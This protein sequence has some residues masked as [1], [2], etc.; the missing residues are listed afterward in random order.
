M[1]TPTAPDGRRRPGIAALF[2][3][4]A[5]VATTALAGCSAGASN[6]TSGAAQD[7]APAPAAVPS[8]AA[9]AAGAG[10]SNA[11]GQNA[12][13]KDAPGQRP[14]DQ[15]IQR[16]IIYTGSIT[17]QVDDVPAAAA[18][19]TG[20][21]TGVG[22]FVGGDQRQLDSDHSTAT[23]TLRVPADTFTSTLDAVGR[24]GHERSRSVSTQDVTS[25]V[26][27]LDSRIKTQQASVDRMRD[28]LAKAQSISDV[29]TV[30]AEL[31]KREADLESMLAQ[32]RN[33]SDLTALSTIT[34]N[35]LG[36][37][38]A[39]PP[40]PKPPA[41]GFI[42]GLQKGWHAF[43]AVVDGLLV[44][45]GALLPFIIVLGVPA[46]VLLRWHRRRRTPAVP[47]AGPV[48][49]AVP[50]QSPGPAQPAAAMTPPE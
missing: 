47:A 32:Q 27:D 22:G 18:T 9:G 3:G 33:L 31:T 10:A 2:V 23:L 1:R 17:L 30:E 34:V 40:P 45:L 42:G 12:P 43:V 16:S 35:L 8:A 14:A 6:T 7:R 46:F 41:T 39:P 19:I 44:V 25:T 36:K 5:I 20:L 21:A 15:P 49:P 24:Q 28:L 38:A 11:L 13:A 4:V 37:D 50:T 29:A 26:I 48:G